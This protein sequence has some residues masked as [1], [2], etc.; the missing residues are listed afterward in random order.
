MARTPR[1]AYVAPAR[2]TPPSSDP[3]TDPLR[4]EL[5]RSLG[6]AYT[7][8]RELGG[9]AM[10]RVFVAR[11]ERLARD[12]VVKVVSP[13]L[14]VELS[15]ERFQREIALAAGLQEPHIVPV[16]TAG[17]TVSGLPYYTMPYVSGESLRVRILQ[18]G[19][20][21]IGQSQSI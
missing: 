15:A 17:E 3:M 7:I 6:T 20:V 8:E 2:R 21:P 9:G 16:L 11:D 13:S 18:G 4:E 1:R 5:Q 19:P 12:V 10:A 14:A